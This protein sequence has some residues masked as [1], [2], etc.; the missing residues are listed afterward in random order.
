MELSSDCFLT[1]RRSCSWEESVVDR[2]ETILHPSLIITLRSS[3]GHYLSSILQRVPNRTSISKRRFGQTRNSLDLRQVASSFFLTSIDWSNLIFPTFQPL[4]CRF[5]VKLYQLAVSSFFLLTLI[6]WPYLT[7]PTFQMQVWIDQESQTFPKVRCIF[8]SRTKICST[9][10]RIYGHNGLPTAL[11]LDTTAL[12]LDTGIPTALP[13]DTGIP[14]A[15]S[16]ITTALSLDTGIPIALALI[17]TA[18]QP[19]F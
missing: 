4:K 12:S 3:A 15:L 9:I 5:L 8:A 19:C 7:S 18:L 17:I 2:G 11:P 14:T 16:L 1:F 10:K 13:V 6:G